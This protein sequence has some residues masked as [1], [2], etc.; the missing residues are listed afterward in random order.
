[1][2]STLSQNNIHTRF[3]KR[4]RSR[5]SD[6]MD[7]SVNK[8]R[9]S[10]SDIPAKQI[11]SQL[12]KTA[13]SLSPVSSSQEYSHQ[14]SISSSISDWLR[15]VE[16]S[17]QDPSLLL[18]SPGQSHVSLKL[19]SDL[20][21]M[22]QGTPSSRRSIDDGLDDPSSSGQ[23]SRGVLDTMY[24]ELYLR[25]NCIWMELEENSPKWVKE[26]QQKLLQPTTNILSLEERKKRSKWYSGA[27]SRHYIL[28]DLQTATMYHLGMDLMDVQPFDQTVRS[29]CRPI[30]PKPDL[31]YGYLAKEVPRLFDLWRMLAARA[32][33]D[34]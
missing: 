26:F 34:N 6:D 19:I 8:R 30:A 16:L 7:P 21:I 32:V 13:A 31:A 18:P 14:R 27:K 24:A 3:K 9:R 5:T 22:S 2:Y 1:M 11:A 33:M 25:P 4:Y 15:N 28:A 12:P 20:D 17:P 29:Y 23:S 10:C